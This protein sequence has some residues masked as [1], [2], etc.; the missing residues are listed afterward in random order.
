VL[1]TVLAA[2]EAAFLVPAEPAFAEGDL[3]LAM[4]A[5]KLF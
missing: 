3:R 4:Q 1:A 2:L 5:D